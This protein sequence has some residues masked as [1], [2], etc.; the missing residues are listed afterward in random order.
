MQS[1]KRLRNL[2]VIVFIFLV[3]NFVTLPNI[4]SV[5]ENPMIVLK[6]YYYYSFGDMEIRYPNFL[7]NKELE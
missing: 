3:I 2:I 6:E 5:D 7:N 1:S 4:F